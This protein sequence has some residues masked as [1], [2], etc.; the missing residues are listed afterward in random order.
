MDNWNALKADTHRQ[1]GHYSFKFLLK[2]Y[3]VNRTFRVL[4]TMRMCKIFSS[5]KIL[6][7]FLPIF[8]LLHKCATTTASMDFPWETQIE[9]GLALT[10]GWGLVVNGGAKIGKNVTMLHGVTLGRRDR[11]SKSGERSSEYPVIE[12]EV[13]IGPHAVIVGSVVVGQGSRIAAGALVVEDVPP[14]STVMGNPS[15]IV[16]S[17][18]TPDVANPAP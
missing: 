11:I 1:Y 14:Y 3:F 6:K 16:K 18:C 13:W 2:G 9:G 5:K 15:S 17:N 7:P 8:K 4:I 12:D 10:H